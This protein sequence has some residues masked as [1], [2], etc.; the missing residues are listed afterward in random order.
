MAFLAG[1]WAQLLCRGERGVALI[2][3][4][5]LLAVEELVAV[6]G[7]SRSVRSD[8]QEGDCD[9]ICRVGL[10]GAFQLDHICVIKLGG[11]GRTYF[12]ERRVPSAGGILIDSFI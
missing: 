5:V 7:D 8:R 3:R 4:G 6:R 12:D 11:A 10:H 9:G 1:A 2:G